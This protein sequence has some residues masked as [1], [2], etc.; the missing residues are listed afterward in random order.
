MVE[1]KKILVVDDEELIRNILSDVLEKSGYDV[2][3]LENGFEVLQRVGEIA[4]D[5]IL[6]DISMPK[7]D[8]LGLCE[9][10]S[11][12]ESSK[13]IPIILLTA[14]TKIDHFAKGVNLGIKYFCQKPLDVK[15][16]LE[17]VRAVLGE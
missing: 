11:N 2:V 6:S 1:M 16:I 4:P 8:G 10:L 12:N 15:D 5:L 14:S 7:L 3:A 9:A 13:G 17:K